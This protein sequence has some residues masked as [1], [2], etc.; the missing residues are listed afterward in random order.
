[1]IE[2]TSEASPRL[3]ARMAGVFY[4]LIFIAAP[5]GASTATAAKMVITL[6]CDIA[7][8][9]I[10]DDLFRPVSRKLSFLAAFFRLIFVVVM[11]STA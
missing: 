11:Q 4:L 2:R 7:V 5:S 10:F 9:L 1:M 3:K 8:A 6:A